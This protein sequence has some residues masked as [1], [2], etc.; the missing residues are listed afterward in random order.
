MFAD[1]DNMGIKLKVWICTLSYLTPE[2]LGK[3]AS[4]VK[5]GQNGNFD[6]HSSAFVAYLDAITSFIQIY[7]HVLDQC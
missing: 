1:H 5:G 2:A 3:G 6:H 4:G 7:L